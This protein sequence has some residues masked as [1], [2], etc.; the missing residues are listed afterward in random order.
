MPI[1]R[2]FLDWRKPA[3]A[4]AG[5]Y[6]RGRLGRGGEWDLSGV[7]VVVPGSRVGRRLLEILVAIA[8]ERQLVLT[9]PRIVTPENFPEL[10]Y[11][12]KWPFADVLSQQLAWTRAL[13]AASKSVLT[14]FLPFPP[15]P[16]DTLRWLAVGETLRKLHLELAADGLDCEKVLAGAEAVE[17]F[18]EHDR[19][20]ALCELQRLYHQTLDGL[21]LWDVQSA[22]LVAIKNREIA[23]DKQIVLLG[24]VD[25]NGAQRLMLDQVAGRVTALVI[26]PAEM[27]ER[28]DEH[29]CLV[30]GKWTEVELPLADEQI[31]RVDGPADQAEAVTRWLASLN[32]QYRAD[33]IAIG[34][35]D[36]RLAPQIERQLS[37]CGLAGRSAVGKQ[38]SQ[39]GPYRLLKVAADYSSRQRFRDL[40]ALVRHPDVYAWVEKR[41][42]GT[43]DGGQGTGD[44]GRELGVGSWE[45]GVGSRES[46]IGGRSFLEALDEFAGKRLP[47]HL[48]KSRLESEPEA[49]EVL[50]IHRTIDSLVEP[51]VSQP[52]PLAGWAEP[53]RAVLAAVYGGR[54]L[55]RHQPAERYLVKA[56]ESF[57]AALDGLSQAPQAL[58]PVVDASQA[59]RIVLAGLA[60]EA[61]PP[62]AD[63]AAIELLGWLDLPLDDA[64]ATLVTTFN[65]GWIPQ[66]TTADAFLPNRLREALGLL[67]NDRRL[68]RDAYALALLCASRRELKVVVAHRDSEG[69]PLTPSRLLFLTDEDR[70]VARSIRFFGELPPQPP[71]RNLL[72]PRGGP[73]AKSGLLLPRPKRLAEPITA[74]SVTKFR[75]YIACPY[76]F[77]LR[78]VLELQP[79]DDEA[80]ELDG[81]AFG[82]LAH[83][84]LEQ[85]GRA[86]EAKDVRGRTDPEAIGRYL[87]NKLDQIAAARYGKKLARPAVLVQVEQ[88]RFRLREFAK[89]QAG[90]TRDGWQIVF[91]EDSESDRV[92]TAQWPVDGEP[93][94]LR[95]RIDRIDF[96]EA[97]GRLCV[98][99]YKTGDGGDGPQRVHRRGDEWVD[100]QLPLYRHLVREA[101]PT[102]NVPADAV[103]ELGYI[104]LPLDLKSVGLLL[105]DWDE[106]MLRSADERAREI[107]RAIREQRFWPPVSPPPDFFDDVAAICQDRRMGSGQED[108]A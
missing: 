23:T 46:G 78:H 12:A 48:E 36:D 83:W 64:A 28:F 100:L 24:T 52:K 85:F 29:G 72:L 67:H 90:R 41:G 57:A 104:V 102:V 3:L 42:Q 59:C 89:W 101:K 91:S 13:Q 61:I 77:Y 106:A 73:P 35:P 6:L 50:A 92:L 71:R 97:L 34:L 37:Q 20:Q 63:A 5:E 11:Q 2:E 68:A 17:G 81:G 98:L 56:L 44:R 26:A 25:L 88:I 9:P 43:G 58:Q 31:E 22:R 69:N 82:H 45:S 55:D 60:G 1:R 27:A 49:A 8:E 19:W 38:L 65:E 93:F 47:A 80:D 108:A 7:I 95:G 62:A 87:D 40:G 53:L 103:M 51:L 75:D 14:S 39:T 54:E 66:A 10:L 76:R 96:H 32:G 94:T 70:V 30:P 105:A 15:E 74:L 86:D 18:A 21:Q 99:D 16:G 84:V 4:G 79:I 33:Q 107:I